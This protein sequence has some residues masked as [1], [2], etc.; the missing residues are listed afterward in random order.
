MFRSRLGLWLLIGVI[1]AGCTPATPIAQLAP[2]AVPPTSTPTPT[3]VSPTAMPTATPTASA[4]ATP[5]PTAT[6]TATATSTRPPATIAPTKAAP[7]APTVAPALATPVPISAM[8]AT[9]PLNAAVQRSFATAQNIVGELNNILIGRTSK[10]S[11]LMAMYNLFATAPVY[12]VAAQVPEVR[13]AYGLYRQGV[14]LVNSTADKVRRICDGQGGGLIDVHEVQIVQK[15]ASQ[16][17]ALLG[18]ASDLLPPVTTTL[19]APQATVTAAPVVSSMALS[20]L[21]LQTM[22][23]LHTT[24]GQLDGAQTNLD[25]N[26]CGLFDPLY[27]TL[28]M[29]VTLNQ[30]GKA[31]TWIDSYGAY[32]AA[33]AYFQNKLYR[34]HEVCQAG[35]GTIGKSEFNDMRRAVDAAA[36]AAARAYDRLKADNLLGQ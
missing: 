29:P 34:A 7:T 12:D 23:R 8:P 22:E 3:S 9:T 4:T 27:Q 14:D 36:I 21:L 24:G 1:A 31:P 28:I 10:C 11:D 19:P 18:Q 30:D 6:K 32:R 2:T 35:G 25:A 33:I 13:K 17:T 5:T 15:S 20:D 26:F 16:A